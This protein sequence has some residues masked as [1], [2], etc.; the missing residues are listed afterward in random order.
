MSPLVVKMLAGIGITFALVTWALLERGEKLVAQ[1]EVARLTFD[2]EQFGIRIK[3]CNDAVEAWKKDAEKAQKDAL[4]ALQQARIEGK[5]YANER[6]VL[7]ASL[8]I[9]TPLKAG[10][11]LGWDEIEAIHR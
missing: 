6:K 8:A 2:I 1:A 5:K 4:E 9:S 7:Q 11:D 10:C 3:T